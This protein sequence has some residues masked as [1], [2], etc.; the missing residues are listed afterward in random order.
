MVCK[1]CELLIESLHNKFKNETKIT[2][3][4]I[5]IAEFLGHLII[6]TAPFAVD[7]K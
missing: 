3:D 5:K 1:T 7:G 4:L 2:N 6:D